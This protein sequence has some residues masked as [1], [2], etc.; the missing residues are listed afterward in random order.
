M[1]TDC[2]FLIIGAGI[3]G[4]A[5]GYELA[6]LGQVLIL[7]AED[8]PGYHSSG[9]SAALFTRNYGPA[10]VRAISAVS[11][12]FFKS[13]PDGFADH[14]MLAPRGGMSV[15]F[16]GD[17]ALLDQELA[18]GSPDHPIVEIDLAEALRHVPLL[19]PDLLGRAIYE[20]DVLD[21]DVDIIHRGFLK[22]FAS[23]GGKIITDRLVTRLSHDGHAWRVETAKGNYSATTL[24]NA[25]G[26]WADRVGQLAGARPIG[27][28]PKRRTAILIEPP[29]GIDVK[30]M[31]TVGFA[32]GEVYIKPSSGKIMASPGD[33]TPVEPQDIQPDEMDVAV[34]VDWL[35]RHMAINIRR[36]DHSWAGLRSFVA[37]EVPVVGFDPL[38]KNFFWLA[39]QGGFGI[40]MSAALGRLTAGLID[41]G[42]M[43]SE[44]TA[45]GL[46]EKDLAPGRC[47]P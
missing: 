35:E 17:E 25:A 12:D 44:F 47:Q 18:L 27:L 26:A 2:D 40:M 31:P 11:Y 21:M 34:L 9:R 14:E 19:R 5:A 33:Q 24:I 32:G 43:P 42:W 7:E 30:H 13:P 16:K 29:T 45:Q 39:G 10:A 3:S 28:V 20:P 23:R 41:Q 15:A 22:G 36:I 38:V 46:S 8:T 4:A 1:S 37:D 6:R